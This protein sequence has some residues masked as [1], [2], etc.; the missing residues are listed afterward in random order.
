M[1]VQEL[2][3]NPI[4]LGDLKTLSFIIYGHFTSMQVRNRRIKGFDLHLQRLQNSTS[5]LFNID[6][7]LNKVRNYLKQVV[8][9]QSK[10]G[11]SVR[12]NIFTTNLNFIDV[13]RSD[14]QILITLTDA[15]DLEFS[16]FSVKT[17]NY[18]RILPQIKSYAI[19]TGILAH[20]GVG[21]IQGYDD[22]LYLNKHKNILEGTTW[23]IGFYDGKKI[24]L[25]SSPALP[26]ITLKLF[27]K[28]L[29]EHWQI[30]ERKIN[31][32]EIEDFKS[33][34]AL[35]SIMFGKPINKIDNMVY[36]ADKLFIQT[37]LTNYNQIDGEEI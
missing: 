10:S 33:A 3:G 13:G 6:L 7:N 11:F 21:L 28:Q 16:A 12:I 27:K 5:N 30:V 15:V 8:D 1:F 24:I 22:V 9:K 20:K 26:G 18:N 14:I 37:F 31:L 34:F 32:K 35:N 19:G 4:K 25:P 36:K 23:N 29:S 17:M 2:N